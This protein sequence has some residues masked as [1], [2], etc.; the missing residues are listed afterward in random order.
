MDDEKTYV[1]AWNSTGEFILP[2]GVRLQLW[3]VD[4]NTRA[5]RPVEPKD[6]P[7]KTTLIDDISVGSS[8]R[9]PSVKWIES[10]NASVASGAT[11]GYGHVCP[12]CNASKPASVFDRNESKNST[13]LTTPGSSAADGPNE[14]EFNAKELRVKLTE[15]YD[16]QPKII[17]P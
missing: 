8:S 15:L 2:A 3:C 6:R 13:T 14:D 4:E 12:S 1:M 17:R 16:N 11:P 5:L 9:A 10:R 7:K